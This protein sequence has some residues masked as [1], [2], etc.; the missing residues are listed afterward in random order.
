VREWFDCGKKETLL[1]TNQYLVEKLGQ[2]IPIPGSEITDP[3]F[4]HPGARII[5]SK[6]GPAVSVSDG[7]VIKNSQITNSII[8]R[9][10]TIEDAVLKDSL[11]GNDVRLK[12]GRMTANLGD[13]SEVE[14]V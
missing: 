9:N 8:G 12:G 4:I 1:S 13:S 5:N 7:A 2:H 3:V 11:V 6:I 14:S 10:S